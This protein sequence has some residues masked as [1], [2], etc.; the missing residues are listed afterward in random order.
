MNEKKRKRSLGQQLRAKGFNLTTYDR[1]TGYYQVRCSQCEALVI[2]GV[3]C[4]EKGCP[5]QRKE[6]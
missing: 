6:S 4:H 5:N 3:A 1:S 2:N